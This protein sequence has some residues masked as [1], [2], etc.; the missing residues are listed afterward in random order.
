MKKSLLLATISVLVLCQFL[1]ADEAAQ[2]KLA[3]DLLVSMQVD[4]NLPAIR[5]MLLNSLIPPMIEAQLRDDPV[6]AQQLI[7]KISDVFSQGFTWDS[8][9]QDYI[10]L[11]AQTFSEDE[12][13]ALTEFFKT[14]VGRKYAEKSP[15]LARKSM[16]IGQRKGAELGRNID[17]EL[18]AMQTE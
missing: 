5:E 18:K 15:E 4:K 3:E 9:K 11:Y 7:K 17:D 13:R 10:D 6:R 14:P 8:L 1:Y 2:R 16:E 12:L